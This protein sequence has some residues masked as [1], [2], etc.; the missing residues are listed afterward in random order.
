MRTLKTPAD[1]IVFIVGPTA[2]G[3]TRLSVKLAL[4][5][6]GEIISCDSMQIYKG[7]GVLSQAP[8]RK[9]KERI[10]HHL[11][12]ALDPRKEYSAALFR[13]RAT[14]IIKLLLRRGKMPIVVGGSGLYVKA[15][16][17]GLFPSPPADLKFRYSMQ[18]FASRHGAGGLYEKLLRLDPETAKKMHPNDVRRIIRA[19]EIHRSTGKTMTELKLRTKGLKDDYDIRLFGLTRPRDQIYEMI[20]SRIDRMFNGPVLNEAKR[21]KRKVLSKTAR[22][23]L[24]F[25][26]ISG[27]LDN[28]Y[29]LET[30][31]SI[32]K[33]N[34]RRFAKRQLTWFRA[35]KRIRWFD[36][37]RISDAEIVRAIAGAIKSYRSRVRSG[38]CLGGM[39]DGTRA[40]G[41]S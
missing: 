37:Q 17:D 1:T 24:G 19:L 7:M 32:L 8:C 18:R 9:D 28:E 41:N 35:D 15:L 6:D 11:V 36:M 34:T 39:G 21:L 27:Y 23:V 3:K 30:A 29:D 5:L 20:G 25:K 31:K 22:A 33:Q 16:I 40:S 13:V 2:V 10:A 26:E 38:L 12:G 4:R 14:R